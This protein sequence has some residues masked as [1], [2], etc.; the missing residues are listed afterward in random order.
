MVLRKSFPSGVLLAFFTT[1]LFGNDF[2]FL[3]LSIT[4]TKVEFDERGMPLLME[5]ILFCPLEGYLF[6]T[7]DDRSGVF[8]YLRGGDENDTLFDHW[9]RPV[10]KRQQR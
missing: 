6:R 5:G 10:T 9:R 8:P 7:I 1:A 2:T 3:E 4:G